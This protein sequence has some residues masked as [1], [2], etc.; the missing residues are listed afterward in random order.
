MPCTP[1]SVAIC[2]A[3]AGLAVTGKGRTGVVLLS[4][5]RRSISRFMLRKSQRQISREYFG[6]IGDYLIGSI[7]TRDAREIL[8]PLNGKSESYQANNLKPLRAILS[9]AV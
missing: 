9:Y 2:P 8:R 3:L 1:S 5:R 4:P 6:K 7:T